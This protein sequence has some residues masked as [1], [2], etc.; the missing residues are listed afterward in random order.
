MAIKKEQLTA[1]DANRS[2][3]RL[4]KAFNTPEKPQTFDV[5]SLQPGATD[6]AVAEELANFFNRISSEFEPLTLDQILQTRSRKI[7]PLEL[8]EAAARVRRFRK[9]KSMVVGDLFPELVTK[10]AN[11]LAIPLT[12]IFNEIVRTSLWPLNWKVEYVTIIPQN[13]CPQDFGDLRNISCIKLFSK[14]MESFV[15]D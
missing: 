6:C 2:F 1:V 15:L 8:H 13:S 9:P 12:S 11:F 3:F 4:V 10:F 5:R 14:I 7:D